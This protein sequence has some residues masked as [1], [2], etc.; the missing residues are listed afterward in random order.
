MHTTVIQQIKAKKSTAEKAMAEA[1]A[2]YQDYTTLLVTIYLTQNPDTDI[3]QLEGASIEFDE[4]K[5]E[6]VVKAKNEL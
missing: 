6:I 5:N 3:K 1:Q 2:I 4:G